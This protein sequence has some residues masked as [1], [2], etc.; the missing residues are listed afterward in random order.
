MNAKMLRVCGY[1][2][3]T[4]SGIPFAN[5][6]KRWPAIGLI[7]AFAAFLGKKNED[8]SLAKL[9]WTLQRLELEIDIVK[10]LQEL[11]ERENFRNVLPLSCCFCRGRGN[12]DREFWPN[13]LFCPWCN[14]TG[15]LTQDDVDNILPKRTEKRRKVREKTESKKK[16]APGSK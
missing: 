12:R 15:K 4:G 13:E 9:D 5:D 3:Q 1:L 7:K 16:S 2:A 11:S 14:S 8:E 10:R 6:R